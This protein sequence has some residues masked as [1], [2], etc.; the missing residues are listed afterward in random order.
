MWSVSHP[1]EL[2]SD[3]QISSEQAVEHGDAAAFQRL[4]RRRRV[5][6][7]LVRSGRNRGLRDHNLDYSTPTIFSREGGGNLQTPSWFQD[8][9]GR[10]KKCEELMRW[11]E[12]V[13]AAGET[14]PSE[15]ERSRC[16]WSPQRRRRSL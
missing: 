16:R 5:W 3:Q 13:K 15:P 4:M 2:L 12:N 1:L 6:N 7:L 10:E 14:S 11:S 8:Q 9:S